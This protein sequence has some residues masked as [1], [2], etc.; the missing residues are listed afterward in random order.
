M[1]VACL[2]T[3]FILLVLIRTYLYLLCI[4]DNRLDSNLI[5]LIASF[6]L[7]GVYLLAIYQIG[8][9]ARMMD[10]FFLFVSYMLFAILLCVRLLFIFYIFFCCCLANRE[11]KV[12][13]SIISSFLT[14]KL[15]ILIKQ[16]I[17]TLRVIIFIPN[18]LQHI[19]ESILGAS[20]FS[21]FFLAIT[22]RRLVLDYT[23][24][25]LEGTLFQV[26][27]CKYRA[28]QRVTLF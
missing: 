21:R 11:T 1:I 9:F 4:L 16:L 15:D 23:R 12:T 19:I 25:L 18:V 14:G 24:A 3:N 2:D 22:N 27:L 6:L 13:S 10:S 8:L 7:L 5:V 20:D 26:I 28:G 17:T